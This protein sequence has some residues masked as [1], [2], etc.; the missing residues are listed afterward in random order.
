MMRTLQLPQKKVVQS[1][2]KNCSGSPGKGSGMSPDFGIL[3]VEW[4]CRERNVVEILEVRTFRTRD[5]GFSAMVFQKLMGNLTLS[6][7]W[8]E[9]DGQGRTKIS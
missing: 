1:D 8:D 7:L 2:S 3:F 9:Y 6:S 4:V 5:L